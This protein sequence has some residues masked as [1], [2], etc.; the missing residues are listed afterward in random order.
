MIVSTKKVLHDKKTEKGLAEILTKLGGEPS[1]EDCTCDLIDK[2][3]ELV[4][5][6]SGGSSG[7]VVEIN[8]N[9][10][11]E[12]SET[13]T[14][15]LFVGESAN[16][17]R[18]FLQRVA[19]T[20]VREVQIV[21]NAYFAPS[22]TNVILKYNCSSIT[23]MLEPETYALEF[24]MLLAPFNLNTNAVLSTTPDETVFSAEFVPGL[25]LVYELFQGKT[26]KFYIN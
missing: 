22:N 20:D 9:L 26:V 23:A 7:E 16:Q 8:F 2:I 18:A 19:T 21:A 5:N 24:M 17:M 1:P 4:G 12:S 6:G 15:L 14:R 3:A 10:E 11:F 13:G 25:E